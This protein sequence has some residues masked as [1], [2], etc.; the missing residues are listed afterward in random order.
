MLT[1]TDCVLDFQNNSLWDTHSHRHALFTSMW[2]C[3]WVCTIFYDK[4]IVC[5]GSAE[6]WNEKHNEVKKLRRKRL[7]IVWK[8]VCFVFIHMYLVD[9]KHNLRLLAVK[10]ILKISIRED[11]F[12]FP[13]FHLDTVFWP[14]L[15]V[16]AQKLSWSR[17]KDVY[18][19][20]FVQNVSVV[21]R[22]NLIN[23]CLIEFL[24]EMVLLQ[25][26]RQPHRMVPAPYWLLRAVLLFE[27]IINTC[28]LVYSFPG[29]NIR[30]LILPYIMHAFYVW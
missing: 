11:A 28:F 22:S 7:A 4:I 5:S 13:T 20:Y 27:A 12:V 10:A 2:N 17:S 23:L 14:S 9:H 3:A 1:L 6:S 15:F 29:Q 21:W 18:L 8:N 26:L 24:I 19:R 25:P 16:Y 30:T